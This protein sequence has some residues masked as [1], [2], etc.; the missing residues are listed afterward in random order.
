MISKSKQ[1]ENCQQDSGIGVSSASPS[2]KHQFEQLF[3]LE[4]IFM[5]D[6]EST[7][8][9]IELGCSTEIDQY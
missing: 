6:K 3:P 7:R 1:G 4:N 5:R 2:K 9:I 8:E